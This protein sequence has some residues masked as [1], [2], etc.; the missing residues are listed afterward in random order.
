M[1]RLLLLGRCL[2]HVH[3]GPPHMEF[4]LFSSTHQS[5]NRNQQTIKMSIMLQK[6]NRNLLDQDILEI[7]PEQIR[8]SACDCVLF[9]GPKYYFLHFL[10]CLSDHL[11]DC[12][13]VPMT[14]LKYLGILPSLSKPL[15]SLTCTAPD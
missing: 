2:Y 13:T 3:E 8:F 10:Q 6:K 11:L 15:L 4:H 5:C 9:L 12:K 14:V 7:R 1:R